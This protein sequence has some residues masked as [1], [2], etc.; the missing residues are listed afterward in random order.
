ME[1]ISKK[2]YFSRFNYFSIIYKKMYNKTVKGHRN[3]LLEMIPE[4]KWKPENPEGYRVDSNGDVI[5]LNYTELDQ[6]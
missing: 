4:L 6:K 1:I 5:F 3:V 2:I